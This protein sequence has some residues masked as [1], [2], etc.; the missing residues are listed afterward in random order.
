MPGLFVLFVALA[1]L[2]IL[3][4]IFAKIVRFALLLLL[5]LLLCAGVLTFF[6]IA[7]LRDLSKPHEQPTLFLLLDNGEPLVAF[8]SDNKDMPLGDSWK[9][10]RDGYP[11][12]LDI[13]SLEYYKIIAIDA[14]LLNMLNQSDLPLDIKTIPFDLAIATLL[15]KDP[16]AIL[17][18]NELLL[19]AAFA[20]PSEQ[21]RED[22]ALVY[23]EAIFSLILRDRILSEPQIYYTAFREGLITVYPRTAWYTFLKLMPK[24]LLTQ[25]LGIAAHV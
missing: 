22:Q 24:S 16:L 23:K 15:A 25:G 7:D 21:S 19:P 3:I 5:I 12:N 17:V 9:E 20:P 10:I 11:D 18:A 8:V 1:F 6:V 4:I 14:S 13:L 2:L